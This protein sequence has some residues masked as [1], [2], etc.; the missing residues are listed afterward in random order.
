MIRASAD[1]QLGRAVALVAL[2]ATSACGSTS[3]PAPPA[4]GSTPSI[5]AHVD[6]TRPGASIAEADLTAIAE[7]ARVACASEG[8]VVGVLVPRRQRSVVAAGRFAPAVPLDRRS[9]YFAGSV[10][11]LLVATLVLQLVDQGDLALEDHVDRFIDWPRGSELTIDMLLSHRSGMGDFGN[12]FSDDL[13]DLVL[14]DLNRTF[15]YDEVL[16]IVASVPPVGEPDA[17][18]HYSNANYIVLGAIVEEITGLSLGEAMQRR[19][20]E[21]LGLTDSFSG[22][23]DLPRL[24]GVVFHGLFDVTG[25]GTPIDIGAFP[26]AAAFTVDPAGSGLITTADETLMLLDAMFGTDKLLS[27][28]ARDYLASH[29]S[30]LTSDALLL[31]SSRHIVGHGGASPGAQVIAAHDLDTGT[32]T[33]AWCNRLDP[34]PNELLA[35]I[36]ASHEL[37]DAIG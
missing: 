31:D 9:Q 17:S 6:T 7:R 26:R 20:I 29:V 35:T 37:L 3:P 13:R 36:L 2:V 21:P 14:A 10:T 30:T 4:N 28:T 22:P 24:D 34:G 27:P 1:H 23:D 32:S 11:K 8:A 25:N 5:E 12:D 19:V 18:Y 16:E 15:T 33:V